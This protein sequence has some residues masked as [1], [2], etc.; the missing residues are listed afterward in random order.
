MPKIGYDP[1]FEKNYKSFVFGSSVRKKK[2][3]KA[4]LLFERNPKH[5]SLN[6]E[7]LSGSDVWTIRVDIKNR[8]FFVWNPTGD[9][10]I[11]FLVGKHDLYKKVSK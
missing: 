5:P 7:K 8:L 10:A 9:T 6:V 1:K 11:F 3:S 4:L 2:A